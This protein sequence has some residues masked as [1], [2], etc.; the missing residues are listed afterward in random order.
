MIVN[1]RISRENRLAVPAIFFRFV[2]VNDNRRLFVFPIESFRQEFRFLQGDFLYDFIAKRR[3]NR[4][5][6][7]DEE[8]RNTFEFVVPRIVRLFVE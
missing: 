1:V 2:V 8:K 6:E 3:T 5:I 4:T 7:L